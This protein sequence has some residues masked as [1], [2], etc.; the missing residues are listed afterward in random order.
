MCARGTTQC[1]VKSAA[2]L[3]E[4]YQTMVCGYFCVKLS[5]TVRSG[6]MTLCTNIW[7][8]IFLSKE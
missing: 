7:G 8:L 4:C 3:L 6:S 5:T 1:S 2:I